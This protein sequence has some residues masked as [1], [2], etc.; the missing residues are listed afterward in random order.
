[1]KILLVCAAGMSTSLV[2]NKM[3]KARTAKEVN[4]VI[5]AQP[6]DSL[7]EVIEDYDVV[8]LG[9][10]IKYK[11]DEIREIADEHDKACGV[12]DS[13][14]YGLGNGRNIL[15]LAIKLNEEK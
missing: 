15:D 3:K 4:W 9:P 6:A 8:L 10:Q 5:E 7:E 13:T 11:E 12:I 1:M 14:D 2:V